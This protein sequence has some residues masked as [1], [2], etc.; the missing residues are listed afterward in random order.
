MRGEGILLVRVVS[1]IINMVASAV[2]VLLPNAAVV[3]GAVERDLHT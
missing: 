2:V 3:S 1:D